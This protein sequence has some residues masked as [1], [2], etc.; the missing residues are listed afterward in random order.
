MVFT[1]NFPRSWDLISCCD[2]PRVLPLCKDGWLSPSGTWGPL[3]QERASPG[4][5]PPT[6]G[7]RT[8]VFRLRTSPTAA[9]SQ[10]PRPP[11]HHTDLMHRP[12]TST[13]VRQWTMHASLRCVHVCVGCA[14]RHLRSHPRCVH[15]SCVS[16]DS[17]EVTPLCSQHNAACAQK[18]SAHAV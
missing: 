8:G 18:A 16:H 11:A 9:P 5:H 12:L 7:E 3:Q 2:I 10:V 6:T 13:C 15:S 1:L 17:P 14:A 4:P